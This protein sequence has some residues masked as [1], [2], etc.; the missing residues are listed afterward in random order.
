MAFVEGLELTF[1]VQHAHVAEVGVAPGFVT[2]ILAGQHPARK[3]TTGFDLHPPLLY[4]P[5][6]NCEGALTFV[7]EAA[8]AVQ[9]R[10]TAYTR[11]LWPRKHSPRR[12]ANWN[13]APRRQ[14]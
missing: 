8:F 7:A 12:H 14:A 5:L 4:A 11:P 9:I 6:R 3:A 10:N 1:S 2:H 13:Q